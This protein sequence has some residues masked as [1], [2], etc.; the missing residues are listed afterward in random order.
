M[1][2]SDGFDSLLRES[3]SSMSSSSIGVTWVSSL[4]PSFSDGGDNLEMGDSWLPCNLSAPKIPPQPFVRLLFSFTCGF[5]RMQPLKSN[6][7][8]SPS[9]DE[10][11]VVGGE[12]HLVVLMLAS[13]LSLRRD[14]ETKSSR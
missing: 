11:V 2:E 8:D 14:N 9:N 1:G 12:L 5:D 6:G 4:L 13:E 3:S 10:A 7:T